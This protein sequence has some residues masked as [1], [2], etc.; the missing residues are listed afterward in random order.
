ML[1]PAPPPMHPL[2]DRA[3]LRLRERHASYT[4]GASNRKGARAPAREE[5]VPALWLLGRVPAALL[6]PWALLRPGRA[7]RGPGPDVRETACALPA[8]IVRAGDV[9]VHLC[10]SDWVRHGHATD[11]AYGGGVVPPG[12]DG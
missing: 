9:E 1:A 10:A 8:G 3:A 2:T 5:E 12:V 4:A 6:A 7:G 11:P